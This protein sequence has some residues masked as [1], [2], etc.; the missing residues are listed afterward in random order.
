MNGARFDAAAR[1][2]GRRGTM[3]LLLG[4]GLAA[5]GLGAR[6]AAQDAA[7]PAASPAASPSAS[8]VA[9]PGPLDLLA[10]TPPVTGNALGRQG[11]PCCPTETYDCVDGS[12]G[13]HGSFRV[14]CLRS[15]EDLPKARNS[16]D[17]V[18]GAGCALVCAA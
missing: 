12:G 18:C 6:S 4:G 2:V 13:I 8:P 9:T 3:R 14:R 17:V 5:I 16:C 15:Q 7:T 11:E 10:G 1:V